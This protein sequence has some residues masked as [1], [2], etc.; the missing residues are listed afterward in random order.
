MANEAL[1]SSAGYV[2]A[3]DRNL[4]P[5]WG[6]SVM[7]KSPILAALCD[8]SGHV[9]LRNDF[10]QLTLASNTIGGWTFTNA[11]SG[12]ITQDTTNPNGVLKIDSGATV[13]NQGVNWQ[14][15]A[16]V[17][18]LGT[19]KPIWYKARFRFTGLTSLK[20]QALIGLAAPQTALISAGAVSTTDMIAL[21]GV[22]TTGVLNANTTASATATTAAL[23]AIANST[24]YELG[25]Y[26]TPTAAYF[27]LNGAL[28]AT[29]TTN[30]PT[31][32]LAP[33]FCCLSNGTV[34]PVLEVD[35]ILVLG[36]RN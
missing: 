32:A 21:A 19:K 20:V 24:W 36:A 30:I 22:T 35:S 18:K 3:W 28:V 14:L 6:K 10:E 1:R 26:A 23:A 25:I 31:S 29:N 13:A 15:N 27:F 11:T 4:S 12:A 16:P 33:A 2:T 8:T 7:Q 5:G 9:L 34:Q 17:F